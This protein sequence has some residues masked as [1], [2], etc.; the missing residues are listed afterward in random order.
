MKLITAYELE[1]HSLNTL[2]MIFHDFA[3]RL[4]RTEPDSIE[5]AKVMASL[6]NISHAMARCA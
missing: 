5:R 3:K 4:P 6:Q 1:N 2:T